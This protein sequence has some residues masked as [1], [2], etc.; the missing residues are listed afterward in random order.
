M[1]FMRL[2]ATAHISFL[3]QK[4][5]TSD[6]IHKCR[7]HPCTACAIKSHIISISILTLHITSATIW[8]NSANQAGMMPAGCTKAILCSKCDGK[9]CKDE[10]D[11]VYL[12]ER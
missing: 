1:V 12:S 3:L 4:Y 5:N 9:F 7:I 6:D 2:I 8:L 10:R 11:F